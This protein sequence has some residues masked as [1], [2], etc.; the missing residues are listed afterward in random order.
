MSVTS[1]TPA[2]RR[3]TVIPLSRATTVAAAVVA[4]LTAF[5]AVFGSVIAGDAVTEQDLLLGATRPGPGY[6][7]GTN[8]LGQSIL[9]LVMAGTRTAVVGAVV[10]ALGAMVLGSIAGLYA[11]YRGGRSGGLIMRVMDLIY[12]VPGLLVA[13]VV[14]GVVGGGYWVAVALL[15]VLFCPYDARIVRSAVLVQAEQPYVEASELLGVSPWSVMARDIWPNVRGVEIANAFLNF[16]FAMVGLSALSFLGIGVPIG[17]P[18][19]G[20]MIN[21]GR[22]FLDLN[23][24]GVIAPGVCL[25]VVAASVTVLGDWLEESLSDAGRS[26]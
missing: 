14:A 22:T 25:V 10:V 8:Q 19:W 2:V 4:V 11:G 17:E 12:S 24:W 26:Q 18:D 21:D 15:V 7:L 16:A 6:P 20:S 9:A 3:R 5:F 13:V 23:P 1:D